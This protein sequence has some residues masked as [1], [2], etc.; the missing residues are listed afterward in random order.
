MIK[1]VCGLIVADDFHVQMGEL[2]RPRALAAIPF[3]G[4]Y[5]LIDFSISNMVNSGIRRIAVSTFYK[6]QSLMDHIG[7]GSAWDLDRKNGGLFL[8][9]PYVYAESLSGGKGEDLS[10]VIAFFRELKERYVIVSG[11]NFVQNCTYD[12]LLNFHIQRKADITILYNRDGDRPGENKLI[13]DMNRLGKVKTVYE[14]P[15]RPISNRQTLDLMVMEREL[16][17]NILA[18]A[19]AKGEQNINFNY[20]PK[21]CGHLNLYAMEYKQS[22]LRINTVQEYFSATM[23][24][25]EEKTRREILASDWPIF[26]KIKDEAPT[27]YS[28]ASIVSNSMISDGSLIQGSLDNCMVFRG[29]TVGPQSKLRNCIVFQDTHIS[30]ACDL[31]NVIIDKDCIIRPGIKLIGQ[32]A[33][34]VLIGKGAVV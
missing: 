9:P 22:V 27:Y 31:E 5:R 26:T 4:R 28:D 1:D 30:E 15:L 29:V 11:S 23:Q 33:Y 24:L 16:L 8:L 34:P 2:A 14:N 18:D 10:G 20:F 6:Y 12:E 21:L 25:L 19:V 3:A 13:L 32:E 7:T 17:V